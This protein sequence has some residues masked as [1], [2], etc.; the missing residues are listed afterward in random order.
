MSAFYLCRVKSDCEHTRKNI[1]RFLVYLLV[2]HKM[3]DATPAFLFLYSL[4]L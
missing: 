4:Y 3:Q 2:Y 1:F